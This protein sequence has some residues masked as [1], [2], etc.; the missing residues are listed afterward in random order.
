MKNDQSDAKD[1]ELLR[2]VYQGQGKFTSPS[3]QDYF[4][5]IREGNMKEAYKIPLAP[6]KNIFHNMLIDL[7]LI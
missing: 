4:D 2:R 3:E 1:Y 5:I 7:F 6:T